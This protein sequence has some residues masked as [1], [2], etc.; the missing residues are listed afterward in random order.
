MTADSV[1]ILP[2]MYESNIASGLSKL[3]GQN[4][5]QYADTTEMFSKNELKSMLGRGEILDVVRK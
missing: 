2:L 5:Q 4:Y 1:A 3:A